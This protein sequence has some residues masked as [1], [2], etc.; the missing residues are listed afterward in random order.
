LDDQ[1]VWESQLEMERVELALQ[2]TEKPQ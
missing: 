1:A 2:R